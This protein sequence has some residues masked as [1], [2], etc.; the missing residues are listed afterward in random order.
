MMRISFTTRDQLPVS[1]RFDGRGSA[2]VAV[3]M[4]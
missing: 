1:G 4:S 2:A 3:L